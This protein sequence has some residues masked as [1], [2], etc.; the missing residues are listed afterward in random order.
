MSNLLL[1]ED[2]VTVAGLLSVAT[3]AKHLT[4][5]ILHLLRCK[6]LPTGRARHALD[7]NHRARRFML[8]VIS[9]VPVIPASLVVTGIIVPA[10]RNYIG[11]GGF[12]CVCKGEW[13]G[14]VVALKTLH[15][16]ENRVVRLFT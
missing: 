6:C 8:K 1:R 13:E 2:F 3:D 14:K 15:K 7:L 9:K 11:S 12:G 10:E 16:S 5:F 4:D